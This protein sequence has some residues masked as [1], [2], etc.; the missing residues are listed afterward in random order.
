MRENFII[1]LSNGEKY[2]IIDTIE[3]NKETYFL[4]TRTSTD[5]T[6]I[7]E[8]FE[9]CKYDRINNNFD[10]IEYEDEYEYIKQLFDKRLEQEKLEL[11]IISKIDFDELLKIEVIG[12]K[13][14]DYKLKY[15]DKTITKNIE[16]YSKTKPQVGDFI[17][18]SRVTLEDDVLTYGHIHNINELNHNNIIVIE[19]AEKRAYLVRYYG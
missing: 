15:E 4:I 18:L 10:K 12:V 6:K 14:Y 17:Y 7:S 19:K 3:Y 16:F 1:E 9:I 5:E 11:S 13:K 8:Q 2:T